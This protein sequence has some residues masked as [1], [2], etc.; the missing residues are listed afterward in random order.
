MR[1]PAPRT[2]LLAAALALAAAPVTTPEAR[3]RSAPDS[4][5]DLAAQLLPAVVNI[6][7]VQDVPASAAPQSP[8]MPNFPPGSPFEQFFHDFMNRSHPRVPGRPGQQGAGPDDGAAA[9][10]CATSRAWA[11]ASSSTHRASW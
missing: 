6:S 9:A 2:L 8:D 4:F 11:R 7:S 3:A 5:A 1:P 10:A